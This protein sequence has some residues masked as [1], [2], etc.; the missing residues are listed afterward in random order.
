VTSIT[1]RRSATDLAVK[2]KFASGLPGVPGEASDL[3]EGSITTLDASADADFSIT[4]TPPNQILN[5]SLPRGMTGPVGEGSGGLFFE[6]RTAAASANLSDT[7]I[8]SIRTAGFASPGDG[9]HG[10]YARYLAGNPYALWTLGADYNPNDWVRNST[11]TLYICK[12]DA[13]TPPAAANQPVHT[14]VGTTVTG[15]DNYAWTCT[16]LNPAY[17]Q[18]ADGSWWRLVPEGGKV[19][20]AQFGG[21]NDS[22]RSGVIGTA[23]DTALSGAMTFIKWQESATLQ[24]AWP[25]DFDPGHYRYA[26]TVEVRTVCGFHGAPGGGSNSLH[27]YFHW[28][29]NTIPMIFHSG[30]TVGQS[31]TGSSL[32]ES[33]HSTMT[34]IAIFG[35]AT[36]TNH[37]LA[38]I[39]VRARVNFYRI[40]F[41]FIAGNALEIKAGSG[42]LGGVNGAYFEEIFFH[43]CSRDAIWVNG[44]DANVCV[45]NHVDVHGPGYTD[46]NPISGGVG[47]CAIYD[48]SQFGNT[49]I[50]VHIAGYG[51][52]GVQ[53]GGRMFYFIG[54]PGLGLGEATTPG[55]NNEIWYDVG[56]LASPSS[57]FPAWSATPTSPHRLQLPIWAQADCTFENVYVEAQL[58]PCHTPSNGNAI[59]IGGIADWSRY[60]N[61]LK[62]LTNH[63]LVSPTGLGGHQAW[64]TGEAGNV[65]NGTTMYA[66]IG[67]TPSIEPSAGMDIFSHSRNNSLDGAGV[68]NYRYY[69]RDLTYAFGDPNNSTG[70]VWHVTTPSTDRTFGRDV[71]QPYVFN[72][73]KFALGS[74]TNARF[75]GMASDASAL[76]T[77]YHADGEIILNSR[78][79]VGGGPL[80]TPGLLGWR[81]IV[82]G[83]PGQLA[84]LRPVCLSLRDTDLNL[85]IAAGAVS[86][87]FTATVTGAALGDI[88]DVTHNSDTQGLISTGWVSAADTVKY[89]L[90]NPTAG[91]IST[92]FTAAF[93]RVRK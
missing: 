90:Y 79:S 10:L 76:P 15:A 7:N 38:G 34:D 1:L 63:G 71:I 93:L 2:L 54:A 69:N 16:A 80:A 92:G 50:G 8:K 27:T 74:G 58:A 43:S 86:A 29:V 77:G 30:N 47:G 20:F 78:A 61:A 88:V 91:S 13:G 57:T 6:S 70:W 84:E 51:N 22:D 46:G 81:C 28:P 44:G 73:D 55:T 75:I 85:T 64:Q 67:S 18:S 5:L 53:H 68:W 49:Y 52:N 40:A 25:I 72:P 9:G 87:I 23:N 31:A 42:W 39:V 4:G 89:Q 26:S 11:G 56:A 17:F 35:K 45:F 37:A 12:S 48:G 65:Y 24:Y 83:N 82:P 19:R 14:T 21:K 66:M 3:Q 62:K 60:S 41:Y 33:G 32:G 59:G 36:S